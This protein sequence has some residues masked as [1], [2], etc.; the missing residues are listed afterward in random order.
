[1][2]RVVVR[3]NSIPAVMR[4]LDKVEEDG[5]MDEARLMAGELARKVW[6]LYGYIEQATF[7][8]GLGDGAEVVCGIN[9]GHGFYSRFNEWGT[10]Y[11]APRPIV[12]PTAHA[13]EPIYARNMA[14]AVREACNAR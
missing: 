12:G 7:A 1:M 4:A 5:P 3:R 13:H 11:Q 2:G 8:R 6:H 9:R 14:E 10:I